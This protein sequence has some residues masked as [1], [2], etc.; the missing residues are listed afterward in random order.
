[1]PTSGTMTRLASLASCQP[2]GVGAGGVSASRPLPTSLADPRGE[3][4]ADAL[5][6][7]R[8]QRPTRHARRERA[9]QRAL[10]ADLAH[11]AARPS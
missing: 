3:L 9:L 4:A 6:F 7:A 11:G 5:G 8:S 2:S 10:L 1:M